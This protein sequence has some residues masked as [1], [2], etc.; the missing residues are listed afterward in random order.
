MIVSED[1][2]A[3]LIADLSQMIAKERTLV[4]MY[5]G[6]SKDKLN[7]LDA[8]NPKVEEKII[9][10]LNAWKD[11]TTKRATRSKLIKALVRANRNDVADEVRR[12]KEQ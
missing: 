8:E 1:V 12:F 9:A 7:A 4:G 6:L 10:M 3:A 11:Q 2:P 5:L